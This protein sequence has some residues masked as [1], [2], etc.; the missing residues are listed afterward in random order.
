MAGHR[1]PSPPRSSSVGSSP[2]AGWPVRRQP[3]CPERLMPRARR[4]SQGWVWFWPMAPSEFPRHFSRGPSRQRRAWVR[5]QWGAAWTTRTVSRSFPRRRINFGRNSHAHGAT[6]GHCRTSRTLRLWRVSSAA[7]HLRDQIVHQ[8]DVS[9]P[10]PTTRSSAFAG[11]CPPPT[12]ACLDQRRPLM[13]RPLIAIAAAAAGLLVLT[14]CSSTS[15]TM[16]TGSTSAKR[17]SPHPS[18]TTRFP[19]WTLGSRLSRH[20]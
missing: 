2:C 17:P 9:R 6:R 20:D 19:R 5:H 3:P 16:S 10:A 12:F 13:T 11:P 4:P 8:P 14:A 7:R 15:H 18:A 1:T